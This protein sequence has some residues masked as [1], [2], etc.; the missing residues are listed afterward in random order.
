M[1]LRAGQSTHPAMSRR[2]RAKAGFVKAGAMA[3]MKARASG[4]L[5]MA[6]SVYEAS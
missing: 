3:T 1:V 4:K 2:D 5:G 6:F